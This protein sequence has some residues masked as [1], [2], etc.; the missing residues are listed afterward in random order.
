MSYFIPG[1]I[2]E[3]VEKHSSPVPL[4]LKELE[5]ETIE[6][7]DSPQ[8]LSGPVEGKFLQMLI[9][10]SGAR[11][12][13]E[14]GT[15]TGYSALMMAEGLPDNGRLITCEISEVSANIARKYFARSAHGNKIDLKMG[16]AIDTLKKI[17]EGS[18]DFVFL[19]ADKVSYSLYYEEGLRILKH[20]GLI[21]ADNALWG[22][23]VI[24]PDDNE[25]RAIAAFNDLVM[26]DDRAEKVML[27]M[28]DG[29]YLIRKK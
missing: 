21:A 25:S 6:K 8:M 20:G 22:G 15:F 10:V 18:V 14:I 26:N 28:R 4:L 23:R 12:V 1:P 19:D 2:E 3:Y 11:L 29:V 7:T 13:V 9:K 17:P 27:T 5:T 16:P 24:S